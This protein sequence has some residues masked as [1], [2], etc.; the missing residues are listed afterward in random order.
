MTGDKW[1]EFLHAKLLAVPA[2]QSDDTETA[3]ELARAGCHDEAVTE[4]LCRMLLSTHHDEA[5][6]ARDL[7][8]DYE[9]IRSWV[10]PGDPRARLAAHT[11]LHHSHGWGAD[12]DPRFRV[13][14]LS[15]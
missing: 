7:I 2:G 14:A 9:H 1:L 11:L 5:A 8:G 10:R 4:V 13:D 12:E 6:T 3:I 15:Y